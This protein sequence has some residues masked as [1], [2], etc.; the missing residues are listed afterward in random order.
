MT[1]QQH[2]QQLSQQL[3]AILYNIR[4]YRDGSRVR[5]DVLELLRN[6]PSLQPRSGS[7]T[8]GPSP[9][10]ILY[11]AGTVPIS[12]NSVQ[13]NIPVNIWIIEAYPYSPPIAYVTP[14]QGM[15]IKPKHRH[16]DSNGVVY[17][18]YLSTWSASSC[19]LT[20]LVA[21]MS[22]VFS[23]DPPVRSSGPTPPPP[24]P[25]PPH[26]TNKTQPTRTKTHPPTPNPTHPPPH[27]PPTKHKNK[28]PHHNQH[29]THP[30]QTTPP[31]PPHKP[32]PN[33]HKHNNPTPPH[34]QN[35]HKQQPTQP[36]R[37]ARVMK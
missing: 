5:N 15:I 19:N 24:P 27:P 3:D 32:T 30:H 7:L 37:G 23:D 10:N 33:T 12:Y 21:T 14:V 22:K 36:S 2:F 29:P 35:H 18:P 1:S 28:P 8:K 4:C 20:A 9:Q 25:P 17:L 11:L 26:P 6:T 34:Q 16:V 13:Y 31:P